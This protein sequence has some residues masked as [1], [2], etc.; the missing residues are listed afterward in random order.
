MCTLSDCC[1]F[2]HLLWIWLWILH[3]LWRACDLLC[4]AEPSCCCADMIETVMVRNGIKNNLPAR[5]AYR[6]LYCVFTGA[7]CERC[8]P[9]CLAQSRVRLVFMR[10][11]HCR[12]RGPPLIIS[13]V[14]VSLQSVD[15]VLETISCLPH[16]VC[17]HQPP[18]L[19]RPHGLHRVRKDTSVSLTFH[20]CIPFQ[21]IHGSNEGLSLPRTTQP[22]PPL[23]LARQCQSRLL[24]KPAAPLHSC[25]YSIHEIVCFWVSVWSCSSFHI[26]DTFAS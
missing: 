25:H 6:S 12:A 3:C 20:N 26:E 1:P 24:T 14:T 9:A 13:A 4:L 22:R 7:P 15:T 2:C 10:V 5:L 8:L 16:S 19:W 18:V 23:H 11:L 21:S 17:G